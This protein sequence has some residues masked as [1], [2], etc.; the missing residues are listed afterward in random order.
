M[1]RLGAAAKELL[2][3]EQGRASAAMV[4]RALATLRAASVTE[5]GRE[6]LA[7]G[8]LTEELAATGFELAASLVPPPPKT[9]R[10]RPA[11]KDAAKARE[12]LR[13]AKERER[14]ASGRLRQ[15]ERRAAAL[16]TELDA[17]KR[18]VERLRG[19]ADE[20]RQAVERERGR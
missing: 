2:R 8:R 19:E 11:P 20:A 14:E 17:A 5:E 1:R 10:K 13:E 7:R 4:D 16:R 18:E 3:E 15:A 9:G 6:L 12:R